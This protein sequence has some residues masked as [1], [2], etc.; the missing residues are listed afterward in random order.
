MPTMIVRHKVKDYDTWKK[1]FD[2]HKDAQ[3]A[4]GL[5]RPRIFRRA[6]DPNETI[7]VFDAADVGKAK[8]FG[9]SPDLKATMQTSGVI[10]KPDVFFLTPAEKYTG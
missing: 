6:E 2:G 8:A 4:A 3:T 5:T 10:D 9:A 7:V 1:A